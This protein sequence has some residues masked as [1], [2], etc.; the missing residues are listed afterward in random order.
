MCA[1]YLKHGGEL[2]EMVEQPY[3]A[4][5]VLQQLLAD[6]PNLL[7]GDQ[8]SDEPKRWMLDYAAN[9]AVL[10]GLETIRTAFESRYQDADEAARAL[11]EFLAL[12]TNPSVTGSA[13]G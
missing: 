13:S 5:E 11:A 6:Y 10:W 9:G 7:A 2:V 3:Q 1:I 8:D 12:R 4:E